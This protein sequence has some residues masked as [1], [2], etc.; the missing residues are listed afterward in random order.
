MGYRH[1]GSWIYSQSLLCTFTEFVILITDRKEN[2][3]TH[4]QGCKILSVASCFH[5]PP[6]TI[7]EC[8]RDAGLLHLLTEVSGIETPL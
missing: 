8:C 7:S 5:Q 2:T 6:E 4:I 1:G 3:Y